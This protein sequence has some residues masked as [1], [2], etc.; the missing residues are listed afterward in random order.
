MIFLFLLSVTDKSTEIRSVASATAASTKFLK[1]LD[2]FEPVNIEVVATNLGRYNLPPPP[3]RLFFNLS[4]VVNSFVFKL[5]LKIM[6]PLGSMW[7]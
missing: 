7:S 2:L 5:G 1:G 3:L 4:L 6:L